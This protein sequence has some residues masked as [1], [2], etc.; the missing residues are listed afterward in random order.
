MTLATLNVVNVDDTVKKKTTEANP[1]TP[2]ATN[3]MKARVTS[4]GGL[5]NRF[6][7]YWRSPNFITSSTLSKE[8]GVTASLHSGAV[9]P[10]GW[11]ICNGSNQKRLSVYH[12]IDL[13]SDGCQAT[14]PHGTISWFHNEEIHDSSLHL[15]ICRST[16]PASGVR[17]I[18]CMG[19]SWAEGWL[20][21]SWWNQYRA[22]RSNERLRETKQE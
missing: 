3:L 9:V 16:T 8:F 6:G 19:Y 13:V 15:E 7:I 10:S 2:V 18:V 20:R 4:N 22:N 1:M 21:S 5:S 12:S 14:V 11:T 17:A